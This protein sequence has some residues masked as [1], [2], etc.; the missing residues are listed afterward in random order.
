MPFRA[1]RPPRSHPNL[2]PTPA[3]LSCFRNPRWTPHLS[4]SLPGIGQTLPPTQCYSPGCAHIRA[5]SQSP[6]TS[7]GKGL[8]QLR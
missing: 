2:D 8:S 3:R 7:S 4:D 6:F 1:Q 5:L